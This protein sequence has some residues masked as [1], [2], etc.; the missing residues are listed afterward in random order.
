V[1]FDIYIYIYIYI[2]PKSPAVKWMFSN[3][4]FKVDTLLTTRGCGFSLTITSHDT[5]M[6]EINFAVSSITVYNMWCLLLHIFGIRHY[7][8]DTFHHAGQ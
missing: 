7:T 2:S 5:C 6:C 1:K 3:L 8:C 4:G